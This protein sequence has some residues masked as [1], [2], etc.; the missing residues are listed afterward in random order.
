MPPQLCLPWS[1]PRSTPPPPHPPFA[2]LQAYQALLTAELERLSIGK[3]VEDAKQ[4]NIAAAQRNLDMCGHS[5][6][7]YLARLLTLVAVLGCM[8]RFWA[9]WVP[10][11]CFS[12]FSVCL[13]HA[14][15][16]GKGG[17]VE[18]TA[19][20]VAAVDDRIFATGAGAPMLT[21]IMSHKVGLHAAYENICCIP[22]KA[23][24][25]DADLLQEQTTL[26]PIMS[27]LA[28][29]MSNTTQHH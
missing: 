2:I 9:C 19:A 22:A 16:D 13:K 14:G 11:C 23:L 7:P 27:L 3:V 21:L 12:M 28:Q 15:G 1:S 18:G 10:N 8:Y 4:A 17:A 26:E 24:P 20:A 29:L 6:C 5:P 25:T